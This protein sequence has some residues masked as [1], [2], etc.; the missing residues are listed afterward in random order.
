MKEYDGLINLD[1]PEKPYCIYTIT[2]INPSDLSIYIGVTSNYKQRAYKHSK[3]RKQKRYKD[4]SLYI[5]MNDVIENQ[6]L[7]VN[8]KIIEENYTNEEAFL[9]EIELIEIYKNKGHLIL[10]DTKGGKG[11]NGNIPWN[12]GKKL[13]K[14]IIKK[15]SDSHLGIKSGMSGKSHSEK[16]KCLISLKNKQRSESDWVNPRKRKVY[17]YSSD[18]VLIET[19]NCLSD[20]A[21]KENTSITSIGEWCRREKK[22]KNGYVYSYS[23]I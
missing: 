15:L 5:W 13:S 4:F 23:K 6:N 9:R 2:S 16:T 3:S 19:F 17:K 20:A 10:N 22:P 18:N 14:E 1:Y 21:L 11:P 12:K 8:F 7:K